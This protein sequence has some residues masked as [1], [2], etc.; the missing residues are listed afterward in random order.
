MPEPHQV[1]LLDMLDAPDT[2]V[3]ALVLWFRRGKGERWRT[4]GSAQTQRE[5]LELVRGS[6]E[7]VILPRGRRP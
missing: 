2:E 1:T 3:A 4:I 7:Y 6:G 5:V